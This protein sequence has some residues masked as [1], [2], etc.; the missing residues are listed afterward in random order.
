MKPWTFPSGNS[1]RFGMA[2]DTIL[3]VPNP[4]KCTDGWWMAI[5]HWTIA[6]RRSAPGFP[7]G[8]ARRR[9]RAQQRTHRRLPSKRRAPPQSGLREW[10]KS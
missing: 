7:D 1:G 3:R 6:A 2:L 10:G 4:Q 9:H 5:P 8:R